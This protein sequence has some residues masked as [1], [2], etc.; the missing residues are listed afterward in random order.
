MAH[1]PGHM[2][3][4]FPDHQMSRER[5]ADTHCASGGECLSPVRFFPMRE[6]L[7]S[8]P[9]LAALNKAALNLLIS[10]G[11]DYAF[12]DG[13]VIFHEGDPGDSLFIVQSGAVRITRNHGKPSETELA[14]LHPMEL[15]GETCLLETL[16][17]TATAQ[18]VGPTSVFNITGR[19]FHHLYKKMPGQYGILL[20]NIA[21]DLS[22][23]LRKL[24]AEYMARR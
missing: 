8:V 10:Q 7:E 5:K 13:E 18:A 2:P 14:T 16:S 6:L 21:R 17:H 24:D 9:I 20:L 22:R 15:F 12:A 23:R 4:L 19:T 1:C 3:L 11:S